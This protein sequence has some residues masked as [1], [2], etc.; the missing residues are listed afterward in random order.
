MHYLSVLS[1]KLFDV[2]AC[3][4]NYPSFFEQPC[5]CRLLR[6]W[7]RLIRGSRYCLSGRG[8]LF[9]FSQRNELNEEQ[10]WQRSSVSP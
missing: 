9:V 8:G 10:C 4:L 6:P 2:K 5:V 3:E 7:Q 1:F